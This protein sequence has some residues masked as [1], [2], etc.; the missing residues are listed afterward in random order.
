MGTTLHFYDPFR[1]PQLRNGAD[2]QGKR[3]KK[4]QHAPAP[5]HGEVQRSAQQCKRND[6][7][8]QHRRPV[9]RNWAEQRRNRK[10]ERM[11]AVERRNGQQIERA[12]QKVFASKD[13]AVLP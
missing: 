8:R 1:K 6:R 12:K 13:K 2:K 9:A 3:G 11:R 5:A 10:A 4:E 7:S